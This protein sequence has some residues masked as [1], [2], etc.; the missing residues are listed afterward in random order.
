MMIE[1]FNQKDKLCQEVKIMIY[2]SVKDVLNL[3]VGGN[4]VI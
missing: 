1:H 2:H 4:T 3:C